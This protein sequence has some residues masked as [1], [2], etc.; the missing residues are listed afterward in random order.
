MRAVRF[1]EHGGPD[2]LT[3][4]DVDE[5]D[6]GYGQVVVEVGAIGVNPVDTYF[7]EGAYPVPGLPFV[8]GSDLAGTVVSV[9][10]GVERFTLG[11]RVFGTGL[12]NGMSGT[13]AEQVAS[14]AGLLAH[15]PEDVELA[16]AAALA[17]VGTTAWQALVE[18]GEVKP[19]DTVLVHGGSGGV[20]HVAVQLAATMGAH[21]VTTASPDS[22][23]ALTAL[24]AEAAFDY[25][26]P[27]LERAISEE[28]APDVVLDTHMDRYLQLNANVAADGAR[29]V[30]VG[31]DTAEGGFDDIGVTKGKELR[32]QF[33]SMFNTRETDAVLSR[34]GDLLLRDDVSP[35]VH[36]TYE[37]A[38]AGEAQRAV[39]HDS[40]LGKLVL[41]P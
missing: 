30:G 37:L 39:L 16:D 13:Y 20:G 25:D 29:I 11:D 40:F 3:V 32:Y 35:V 26:H 18:H 7:R 8:P 10:E 22:H 41:V 14:P 19:A 12:G 1:H 9:G 28:Y 4:D 23:D 21:V 31:N 34:L 6:P 2:V 17:L 33:M 15:L 27:N 5:P 38:E 36:E 24:G